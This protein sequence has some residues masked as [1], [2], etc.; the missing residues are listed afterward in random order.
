MEYRRNEGFI[1]PNLNSRLRDPYENIDRREATHR[2]SQRSASPHGL[3]PQDVDVSQ[4]AGFSVEGREYGWHLDR[5]RAGSVRVR[6]R[7]PPSLVLEDARKRPHFDDGVGISS[8]NYS[9]TPS[10]ELRLS[11][12]LVEQK[13]SNFN[14]EDAGLHTMRGYGYEHSDPRISKEDFSDIGLSA[15]DKHRSLEQKAVVVEDSVA[16]EAYRSPPNLGPTSFYGDTAVRHLPSLSKNMETQQFEHGRLQYQDPISFARLPVAQS[17]KDGE[18]PMYYLRDVSYHMQS[19]SNSKGLASSSLETSRNEFMAYRDSLHLPHANEFKSPMK[20]TEPVG[21]NTYRE[22]PLLDSARDPEDTQRNPTFYP[23]TYSPKRDEH[24]NYLYSKSHEMVDDREYPGDNLHKIMAPRGQLD[25]GRTQIIYDHRDM[26][27]LGIAQ[28][29]V[30]RNDNIDGLNGNLRKENAYYHPALEKQTDPDYFDMRR[31]KQTDPDYFD[32]GREKQTDPD[33]FD[34]R[35]AP[36]I[37]KQDGEYLGSGF[38]HVELGRTMPQDREILHTGASKD[39]QITGLEA[40]YGFGSNAG[41]QFKEGRL[42]YTHAPKYQSEMNRPNARMQN[43]RDEHGMYKSH[44][45]VVKGKYSI[46]DDVSAY[47]SRTTLSGKLYSS[48]QYED[49]Y[50]TGEEWIDEEADDLYAARSTGFEHAGYRRAERK[51]DV[52]DVPEDF[53][54]D[55]WLSSQELPHARKHSVGFSK[56]YGRHIRGR[57]RPGYIRHHNSQRYDRK[58]YPYRQQNQYDKRKPVY[59]QYNQYDRKNQHYRQHKVWKRNDGYNE[60]FHAEDGNNN[61]D[62]SEDWV[63]P[64]ESEPTEDTEEFKQLVHEAFLKYSKM[65]NVNPAVQRRY[66]EEGKAG[67]LFCIVCGRSA[68]KEFM[69]TQR[70]VTHAFMSHKAGLRAEHLGLHRAIS[71]LLGWS[72]VVPDDTITWVPQV[73][74]KEEALAQKEDL[75]L[76]PPVIIIH[77]ISLSHNN[78]E[79][80]KVVTMEALEA[81]IRGKGLIRGRI[82]VVLGKPAD[83]STMVVKFLG[84]FTGLGDAEKLHKYFA[85]CNRGRLELEL[86]TS[87]NRE[88]SING[89]AGIVEEHMLYGYLGISEDLDKVDYNTRNTGLVKSK[90]EILDLANAPVKPEET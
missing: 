26:S 22:R 81:F 30:D 57:G 4:G 29:V 34:M 53:V 72:T 39:Q 2:S 23:R 58:D 73:L 28:P 89:E 50:E 63:N 55:E 59:R 45:R 38:T 25:Y 85:E 15:G 8:R 16:R 13:N 31:E 35:R 49:F 84:T 54:S 37:S 14:N 47:N 6:S 9:P 80:W 5:G 83:Q 27:R 20:Q 70:L 33:Y 42:L 65:V 10:T 51:Y 60:E 48:R 19:G 90:K 61:S 7:S 32:M 62:P 44:D 74:P 11:R 21:L 52:Q 87:N 76:W 77:N 79:K 17:Y 46:Q 12:E 56:P 43:V 66:K 75:I 78:P 24:E 40:N 68:S 1:R 3:A 88:I 67:S 82:K 86:A 71:V 64:E 36:H 41:P 18:K 69:D